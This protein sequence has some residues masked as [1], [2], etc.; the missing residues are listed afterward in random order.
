[1]T[2]QN[3]PL[4][5]GALLVMFGAT[6][7]LARRKLYPAI[8]SLYCEGK[9][10]E[11]FALVGVSRRPR[12]NEQFRDELRKSIEDHARHKIE[13]EQA[14]QSF[15]AH[16]V[17]QSLDINEIAHF[18]ALQQL[19]TQLEAQFGLTGN[20]LFYLA[21]APELFGKVGKNLQAGG[22]LETNGWHRLVIEKP[23]GYDLPSAETLNTQINE[24]FTESQIFRID[25]YLGK[26]MVQNIHAI[27]FAN[28]LFE[29]LWNRHH[30]ANVQITTSESIGVEERGAYYDQSGALRDMVQNHMLQM[31]A[32]IAMDEP[33]SFDS[34]HIRDE[35]VKV[36]QA[37]RQYNTPEEVRA[38]VARGQYIEG[39][40][41]GQAV[42]AYREE[43]NVSDKSTTE[44]FFAAKL[45]IDNER[46]RGVPFFLR[47]GKRLPVKATEIIIE[48]K[49][50]DMAIGGVAIHSQPNLLVI[51]I[52][53]NEGIHVRFNM[54]KAGTFAQLTPVDLDFSASKRAGDGKSAVSVPEAY[55]RLLFDALRGDSTYF[56]RWDEVASAW[57][58]VDPIAAAW[59]T[60]ASDLQFYS[61]GEWGAAKAKQLLLDEGFQWWPVSGQQ[62]RDLVWYA[63]RI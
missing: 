10:S 58:F 43:L 53:P 4:Q 56:T 33:T 38:H 57:R 63:D 1:M 13:D 12:T 16:F 37:L 59:R 61:A 55:E 27:R 31:L 21:I 24:V 18:A 5:D 6:G 26:E 44:T 48:L 3:Q 23:F 49:P 30:I 17:Y 42:P 22:V 40:V 25:H 62:D 28:R 46:W 2:E 29:P 19:A 39:K 60:D 45:W 50:T 9:L 20:R 11:R 8:Y 54:K 7:D 41:K 35:K 51:R 15:A 32:L 34:E 36:I 52:Q 47:T 14:W